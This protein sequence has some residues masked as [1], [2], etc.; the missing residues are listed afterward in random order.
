MSSPV[1]VGTR[2]ESERLESEVMSDGL[3]LLETKGR[4]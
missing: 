2:C 1:D 3:A 4:V